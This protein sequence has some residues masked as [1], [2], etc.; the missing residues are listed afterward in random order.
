MDCGVDV[1]VDVDVSLDMFMLFCCCSLSG[2]VGLKF[3]MGQF[4]RRPGVRV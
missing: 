3:R 4:D 2:F 1:D